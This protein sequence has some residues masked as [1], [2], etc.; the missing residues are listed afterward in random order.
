MTKTILK[1]KIHECIEHID[2][3]KILEAVYT[4]L[5][6]HTVQDDFEL[7]KEDIKII[8]ERRKA[9]LSGKEKTYSVAEVKKKLLK[10]LGK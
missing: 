9:I 8:S 10:N 3:N 1:E 4:I 7:S 6:K 5:N 2:D